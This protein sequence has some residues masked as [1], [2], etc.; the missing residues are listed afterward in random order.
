MDSGVGDYHVLYG[1]SDI[2]GGGKDFWAE[3]SLKI[4]PIEQVI[5]LKKLDTYE[6]PFSHRSI[7]VVKDIIRIPQQNNGVLSGKTG[8]GTINHHNI[9][10]WFVGYEGKT[11]HR[12]YFAT[13]IQGSEHANGKKAREITLKILKNENLY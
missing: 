7:D 5:E 9:R 1:N 6:L 10:G 13:Y 8:T 3:S 2:S 11:E 4:S 12:Y